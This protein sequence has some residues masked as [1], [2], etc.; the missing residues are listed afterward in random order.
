[1]SLS[2][3]SIMKA[4]RSQRPITMSSLETNALGVG[5]HRIEKPVIGW[6]HIE[7]KRPERVVLGRQRLAR[8]DPFFEQ[9]WRA[10][11]GCIQQHEPHVEQLELRSERVVQR[12]L[13][14]A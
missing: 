2:T 7:P 13:R 1:M 8:A 11:G 4:L 6:A 10:R 14:L 9:R 3:P 12:A 5:V